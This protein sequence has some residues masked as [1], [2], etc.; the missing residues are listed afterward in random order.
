MGKQTI[1]LAK[2]E[3]ALENQQRLM[4]DPKMALTEAEKVNAELLIQRMNELQENLR[5]TQ[6]ALAG[7]ISQVVQA[8]GLDPRQFGIN[9]GAG[10]ILPAGQAPAPTQAPGGNGVKEGG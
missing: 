7:F 4:Q 5:K 6:V 1:N 8:R 2:R 10:R 3:I 9:L